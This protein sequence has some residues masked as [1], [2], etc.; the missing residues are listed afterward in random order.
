MR[1]LELYQRAE[2][3]RRQGVHRHAV[4]AVEHVNLVDALGGFVRGIF[5]IRAGRE[6]ARMQLEK[7]LR[8]HVAFV[9][10]F[11]NEQHRVLVGEVDFRFGFIGLD[12]FAYR[13]IGGRGAVACDEIHKARHPHIGRGRG[14]EHGNEPLHLQ[15]LVQSVAQF[16]LGEIALLEEFFQQ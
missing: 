7:R 2:V 1:V 12:A 3:A 5:Q 9:H 10:R 15:C 8:P 13:M 16:V 4:L 6:R 11:V 14:G